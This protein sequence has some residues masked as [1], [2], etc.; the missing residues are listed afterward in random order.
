MIYNKKEL[1]HYH[2]FV[3]LGGVR[4]EQG[5]K[6]G[7]DNSRILSYEYLKLLE[8]LRYRDEDLGGDKNIHMPETDHNPPTPF[9]SAVPDRLRRF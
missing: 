9:L 1:T 4:T 5:K 7:E 6:Y 2:E 3:S 8:T